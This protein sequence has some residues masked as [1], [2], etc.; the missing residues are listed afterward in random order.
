M[1][2]LTPLGSHIDRF[3]NKISGL[4]PYLQHIFGW[5]FF[6]KLGNKGLEIETAYHF[7]CLSR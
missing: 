2:G 3:P 4:R 6:Q 5:D 1:S 7:H